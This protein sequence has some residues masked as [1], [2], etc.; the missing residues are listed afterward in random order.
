MLDTT[1]EAPISEKG[2]AF[3]PKKFAPL[4]T[5]LKRYKVLYGGRG[6]AKSHSIAMALLILGA[7]S[8]KRILCAREIQNS[9]AESVHQLLKDKIEQLG[10]GSFYKVLENEIRG[11]NGT[12]FIFKGLH[13]ETVDSIKS[14]EGID[15][16]WVEEA[17]VISDRS[18]QI[19]LPTI[20][21]E[22]SEVWFSYNPD[23][24]TDPVHQRFVVKVDPDAWV[25]KVSI[26]DNPYASQTLI[27]ECATSYRN[28]P[29][30]AAWIWG[31]QT[32]PS[33]EG[34]IYEREMAVMVTEQR[35]TQVPY[36]KA[37]DTIV[38]MDLG[39]GDH[40]SLV[41][42]QHIGK[43]R[44]IFASYEASGETISHYIDWIKRQPYRIDG[45]ALPHDS[46]SHSLHDAKSVR[47]KL[48]D[49]FPGIPEGNIRIVNRD[50]NGKLLPIWDRIDHSREMFASTWIDS[51]NCA[52]L[53]QALKKYRKHENKATKTFGDPVHDT[54]SDFC[55][56][57]CYWQ[58]FAPIKHRSAPVGDPFAFSL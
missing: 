1:T 29:V 44:R 51:K 8:R 35:L 45:F 46:E 22:G 27:N 49:A 2:M 3:L 48:I 15:I 4:L 55:D 40:T 14:L 16:A 23:L 47:Q 30:K 6:G 25:C 36:D 34:A 7:K 28:D 12:L 26:H 38:A 53:V 20:R 42:G 31:G 10:L 41:L 39:M 43:E 5:M 50:T 11:V 56:A 32:R 13:S 17:Q 9:I 24:D 18:L 58:L 57:F 54:Y 19:L 21:K 52:D 33:S 37:A